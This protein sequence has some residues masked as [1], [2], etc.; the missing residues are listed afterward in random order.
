MLND[1]ER[2]KRI[3]A[4]RRARA[5]NP[6]V[7][8]RK[9][10]LD[11]A[12]RERTADSR[13]TPE[14]RAKAAEKTRNWIAAN[15][16]KARAAKRRY[17]ASEKG[18]AQKR[19]EDAAFVASGGRKRS[20]ERRAAR[21]LSAARK[22]ARSRWAAINRHYTTAVRAKRRA[23]DKELSPD[24]FW[25]LQEAVAL[26]RLREQ[27]VGGE[28]HVDHIVPI[29]KGGTSAPENLQCVPAQWNRKKSNR[30]TERFFGTR[31]AV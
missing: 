9:A 30:S 12:Y 29:S 25:I 26:C 16:D 2:R 28:W 11:K 31:A 13:K 7:K 17:Y 10:A 8:A 5:Q 27:V 18:R 4:V 15:P 14:A 23:L 24:D 20:E 19:K 6:E 1:E 22:D 21:P 3:N